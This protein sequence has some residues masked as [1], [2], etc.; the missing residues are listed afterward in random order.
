MKYKERDE[1]KREEFCRVLETIPEEK[2]VYI[3][4][5][6]IDH[7]EVKTRGWSPIG[8]P[9]LW[10]K[11]WNSWWRTT[12][13]AWVRG[14]YVLAPF[15]F[16]WMTNTEIFNNWVEDFL[17]KEI[18]HWDYVIL[19]NASFHKS[20]KTKELIESVWAHILFLPPYS[21]DLNPIENYWALLKLY[22]RKFN[23]SFDSFL[24]L[25]DQFLNKCIWL[26]LS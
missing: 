13:I 20:L 18:H 6:G 22:V 2:R 24:V 19:D 17:L 25:L 3:D 12:L 10:E 26:K 1:K 5:S 15:R 14:E 7:N 23:T 8:S 21:P 9:I 16:E 4:E 11:Y